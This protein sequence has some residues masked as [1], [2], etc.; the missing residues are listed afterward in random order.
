MKPKKQNKEISTPWQGRAG[1]WDDVV[2]EYRNMGNFLMWKYFNCKKLY[3]ILIW[4]LTVFTLAL[5]DQSLVLDIFMARFAVKPGPAQS[6]LYEWESFWKVYIRNL[7]CFLRRLT[8][9][10]PQPTERWKSPPCLRATWCPLGWWI[11]CCRFRRQIWIRR[12]AKAVSVSQS[13][14]CII[15]KFSVQ[16]PR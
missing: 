14:I 6:S 5:F 15:Q 4:G 13:T 1:G 16:R 2:M 3:E 12:P 10:P 11:F 9:W 8:S 7:K